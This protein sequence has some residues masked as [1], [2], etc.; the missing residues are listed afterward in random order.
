M[1]SALKL[2]S[3]VLCHFF[4]HI[5][6]CGLLTCK[7]TLQQ[8]FIFVP[9]K[10]AASNLRFHEQKTVFTQGVQEAQKRS[11]QFRAQCLDT[12]FAYSRIAMRHYVFAA[13]ETC[14]S[15]VT[16]KEHE[17]P[18]IP[19]PILALSRGIALSWASLKC[20]LVDIFPLRQTL[21]LHQ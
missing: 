7:L 16:W 5:S 8:L 14:H 6:F 17:T 12:I 9:L 18:P 1:S 13:S 20:C 19:G 2:L 10:Y 4:P 21:F 3:L 11:S 15:V